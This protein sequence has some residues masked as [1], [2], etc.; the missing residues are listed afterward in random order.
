MVFFNNCYYIRVGISE[1]HEVFSTLWISGVTP[2]TASVAVG[3]VWSQAASR[4]SL[5]N[6]P[7]WTRGTVQPVAP[8]PNIPKNY[9]GDFF[10]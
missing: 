5:S 2:S 7:V 4:S 9:F 10:F 8:T 1:N 3:E 6:L